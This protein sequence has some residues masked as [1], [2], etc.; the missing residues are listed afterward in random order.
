MS[1]QSVRSWFRPY[2]VLALASASLAVQPATWSGP[3]AGPHAV[4]LWIVPHESAPPDAVGYRALVWR[5]V[6]RAGEPMTVD[7][8]ARAICSSAAATAA[9]ITF[10]RCFP[11]LA[12]TIEE[13]HPR[14][15]AADLMRIGG[16]RLYAGRGGTPL[17][18][19]RPLI[20]IAGSIS[21]SGGDFISVAE[22]LASHGFVV[23]AIVPP[24]RTERPGFTQESAEG[25]RRAIERTIATLASDSG[26]D[27]SRL[28]LAAWS[29]GGVPVMLEAM[30]NPSVRAV[31]SL[32]SAI[33][34]EYGSALIRS[35]PGYRPAAFRGELLSIIAGIDNS[36]AKDDQVLAALAAARVETYVAAGM[37]HAHFSDQYG[38]LPALVLPDAERTLLHQ[39]TGRL[40]ARLVE[41]LARVTPPH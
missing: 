33:R 24:A 26:I 20:V 38:A 25:T 17:S 32:D 37:S 1:I 2:A 27:A 23:A 18:P 16:Q 22:L 14:T 8:F 35:A 3:P 21:S 12:A 41:F 31:I 29:F 36:V 9:E 40:L 15:A 39:H 4:G 7:A 5:P 30:R 10:A 11:A 28:V 19:A 6:T 34:Y 13:Q